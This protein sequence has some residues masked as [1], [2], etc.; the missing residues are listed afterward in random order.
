MSKVGEFVEETMARIT[1]DT[2]KALAI[3]NKRKAK[4]AF[5]TQIAIK[6]SEIVDLESKVE[7]YDD[8]VKAA[9]YPEAAITNNE[10]YVRGIIDAQNN[11]EDKK[12]ELEETKALQKR[13]K[14]ILASFK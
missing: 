6:D 3:K 14:D 12:E 5:K 11:L 8:A 4:S 1:G 13:M 10:K 7:E 9:M 2:D